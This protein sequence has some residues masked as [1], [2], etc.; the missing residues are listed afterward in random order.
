MIRVHLAFGLLLASLAPA[1]AADNTLTIVI[2]SGPNA[3]TYQ[4]PSDQVLCMHAKK[5]N[6]FSVAWKSFGAPQ[7]KAMKEAGFEV[8]DPDSAKPKL[9]YARVSFFGAEG[10]YVVY[11]TARLP[12]T[13]TMTGQS[14]KIEFDGK[15][16]EGVRIKLTASCAEVE[17]L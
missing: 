14:G 17:Y 3:G 15:T 13:L 8:S 1:Q 7:P 4:A 2:G 16:P 9:G 6:V 12:V 5:Q 10:K 11:Q